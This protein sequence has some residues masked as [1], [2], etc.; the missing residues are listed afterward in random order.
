[1][2]R[3]A[4]V[5]DANFPSLDQEEAILAAAGIR[6]QPPLGP[7]EADLLAAVGEADAFLV[8]DRPIPQ[9]IFEAAPRL[10][11]IAC[12]GTGYD[13]ID[14]AA[15][16]ERRIYVCNVPDY[17]VE[18]VATH[19]LALLLAF[20]RKLPL[21]DRLVRAGNWTDFNLLKPRRWPV[22]AWVSWVL[23]GLVKLWRGSLW[24]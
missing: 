23:A 18:E 16:T 2:N 6:L 13:S 14:A 17:C 24:D 20:S 9:K 11:V 3:L 4:L 8:Q 21:A 12:Y 5:T 10:K 1:M 22:S 15:A 7:T 19:T